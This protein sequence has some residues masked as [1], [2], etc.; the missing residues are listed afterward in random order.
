MD[1]I[2]VFQEMPETRATHTSNLRL[3]VFEIIINMAVYNDESRVMEHNREH[4]ILWKLFLFSCP[5]VCDSLWPH[6]LQHVRPLCP[7]PS[8][9]DC[10]SSCPLCWWCHPA[11]SSS[12]AFFSFCPQSFPASEN[13]PVSQQF[14]SDD[15]NTGVSASASVLPMSIQSCFP[16]RL[17]G[18][19]IRLMSHT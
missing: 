19:S 1:G 14:T 12:D 13:F 3:F 6:G 16:L 8:P 15:Q 17:T 9:K 18:L 11:I 2:S 4:S 7:S 10:P 5:V